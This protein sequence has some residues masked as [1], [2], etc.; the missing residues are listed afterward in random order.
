MQQH[1]DPAQASQSL[2]VKTANWL[3]AS[4]Q[5][6]QK[7]LG[8][9]V[10]QQGE[11]QELRFISHGLGGWDDDGSEMIR[12]ASNR[13]K[14]S[15]EHGFGSALKELIEMNEEE[16]LKD[17]EKIQHDLQHVNVREHGARAFP[18]TCPAKMEDF[19]KPDFVNRLRGWSHR[20]LTWIWFDFCIGMVILA[21]AMTIGAEAIA[22]TKDEDPA[23]WIR[24]VDVVFLLIYTVELSLRVFTYR[25][26]AFSNHWVKFDAFLVITGY[27]DLV[28]LTISASV[29][30]GGGGGALDQIM[31]VRMLRL[32]RL[33]RMVRFFTQFRVLWA[34]VQ[35]LM[36]S[37]N[38]LLWTFLLMFCL[39]YSFA[40]LS[41]DVFPKESWETA[42]EEYREAAGRFNGGLGLAMMTLSQFLWFD[43][44][45]RIY[46][47]LIVEKPATVLFFAVFIL[48]CSIAL[49]NL[50]ITVMVERHME[51]SAQD[52]QAIA[53]RDAERRKRML[54]KLE[55]LFR[56]LDSDGS[57]YIDLEEIQEAPQATKDYLQEIGKGL[58]IEELFKM[59]DYDGGGILSAREFC[60]GLVKASTS[61]KPLELLRLV[62]MSS[63]IM[64]QSRDIV[65]ILRWGGVERGRTMRRKVKAT[66]ATKSMDSEDVGA[67]PQEISNSKRSG[68]PLRPFK[69]KSDSTDFWY[70]L[71]SVDE[72]INN[73]EKNVG[74]IGSRMDS[75]ERHLSDIA[76]AMEV[77]GA[78]ASN[79]IQDY[80]D[81]ARSS[82]RSS[83]R[84]E[85]MQYC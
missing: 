52:K 79:G 57:G 78:S 33:A 28:M 68:R 8:G 24:V 18:T 81:M 17:E 51:Q 58:D 64:E 36:H 72:K 44:T 16:H 27:F 31:L 45:G 83:L 23:L 60:D 11:L 84:L 50:V 69:I 46:K 67:S 74:G 66:S 2:K 80:Q 65:D 71:A 20:L 59:L 56:E 35:G 38:T 12:A 13:S 26:F 77:A 37:F 76:T 9:Q 49:M 34:L 40:I 42:S 85:E 62:S 25:M 70:N 5:G 14:R 48:V 19:E 32:C 63:E 6:A 41:I 39:L 15:G 21:N 53:T 7:S 54:P 1:G 22:K 30:G 73:L 3:S 55:A 10:H 4:L 75:I 47:P 43:S 82:E 61:E 29:E